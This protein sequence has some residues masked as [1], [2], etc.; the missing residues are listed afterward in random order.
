M[1]WRRIGCEGRHV[2]GEGRVRALANKLRIFVLAASAGLVGGCSTM[3]DIAGVPH[4]GHQPDGGYVLLASEQELDCRRLTSEIE[5]GLNDMEKAKPSID[6][7]RN[8]A[9]KTLVGLYGRMFGGADGGLK[10]AEGYRQSERRVRALNQHL[11]SKG[12][13]SVDVNARIMAFNLAPLNAT[14]SNDPARKPGGAQGGSQSIAS[15]SSR[16]EQ[17]D[18]LKSEVEA[19]VATTPAVH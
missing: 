16:N 7:E 19:L 18:A 13:H 17:L 1:V 4:P 14:K 5:L 2:Q 12:C 10:S 11:E 8:A 6:A 3:T 15:S 9:P